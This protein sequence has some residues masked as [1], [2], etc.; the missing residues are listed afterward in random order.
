MTSAA[1]IEI[2]TKVIVLPPGM[3]LDHDERRYYAV[4]VAW[5]G[6]YDPETGRGGYAVVSPLDKHLSRRGSW[7]WNPEPFIQRHYRWER[8]EDA[9]TAA[10]GVVSTIKSGGKTWQE[11]QQTFE[12]Q[13]G[14]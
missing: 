10:R 7:R 13:E 6:P 9:L 14:N 11:F 8:L 1:G 3:P 5:R 12:Q 2:T 4:T